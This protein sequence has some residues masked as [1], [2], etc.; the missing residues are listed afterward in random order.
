MAEEG[1]KKR[2]VALNITIHNTIADRAEVSV[3]RQSNGDMFV[4]I[5]EKPPAPVFTVTDQDEHDALVGALIEIGG[6]D[7]E[8][9]NQIANA[10]K[11]KVDDDL[12]DRM[13]LGDAQLVRRPELFSSKAVG[14]D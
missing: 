1:K 12:A 4:A 7:V 11:R 14:R 8:N 2:G 13:G 6:V 3:N 5:T 10:A 9:A